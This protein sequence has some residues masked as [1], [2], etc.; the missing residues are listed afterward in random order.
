[1]FD[2]GGHDLLVNNTQ[3]GKRHMLA[4]PLQYLVLVEWRWFAEDHSFRVVGGRL[5]EQSRSSK[6]MC[7]MESRGG[8]SSRGLRCGH[9]RGRAGQ[10]DQE[11]VV[12]QGRTARVPDGGL[13]VIHH[14]PRRQPDPTR[15]RTHTAPHRVHRQPLGSMQ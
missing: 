2:G 9:G 7:R 12:Q 3:T 10:H 8:N 4:I 11:N 14:L 6:C 15:A 13:Q 1:M 5:T